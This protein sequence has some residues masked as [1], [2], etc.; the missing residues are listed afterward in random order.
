MKHIYVWH[1]KVPVYAQLLLFSAGA[2]T[3]GIFLAIKIRNARNM[4][5]FFFYFFHGDLTLMLR[6][7]DDDD[8]WSITRLFFLFLHVTY[9]ISTELIR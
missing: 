1:S 8:E 9:S 2:L 5:T 6:G 3:A 4:V 7:D